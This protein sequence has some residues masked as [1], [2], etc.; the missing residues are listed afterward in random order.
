M[1]LLHGRSI[2]LRGVR[3]LEAVQHARCTPASSSLCLGRRRPAHFALPALGNGVLSFS[4][5]AQDERDQHKKT[6]TKH[7]PLNALSGMGLDRPPDTAKEILSFLMGHLW[8]N[9]DS[10]EAKEIKQKVLVSAGLVVAA[11]ALT[12]QVPFIFKELVN[13]MGD[14]S[15]ALAGSPEIAVPLAMVLGYGLA[16]LSASASSELA[17]GVFATV[18][19]KTIRKVAVRVFNHLHSMDLKFHLTGRRSALAH[20]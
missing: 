6:L 2:F 14:A 11:K 20:H 3:R 7:K 15:S 18:A 9:D 10:K 8:P 16:R 17:N 4:T 13:S 1:S 12:I 5:S 19:Q